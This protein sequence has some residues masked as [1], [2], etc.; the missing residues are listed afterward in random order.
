M[1]RVVTAVLAMG[2]AAGVGLGTRS[3]SAAP[4]AAGRAKF[5]DE[6]VERAI[7]KGI[8]YLLSRQKPDGSWQHF[9]G[10]VQHQESGPTALCVYALLESGVSVQNAKIVKA[11]NWLV[12]HP[13]GMTYSV[14]CRAN[15]WLSANMQS[16]G[17]YA[18]YLSNDARILWNAATNG[19]YNYSA[20]PGSASKRYDNSN[21]QFGLLGVWAKEQWDGEVPT[22]YWQVV[23]RHWEQTQLGDGGWTYGGKHAKKGAAKGTMTAGGV[24]SLFVC[25]DNLFAAKFVNCGRKMDY[26]PI[27]RGLAWFDKNF[28]RT[29]RDVTG[30][31][32][33]YYYLYGIERVGLAA[34]Y[35]YFGTQDWY[36]I[37]AM[38]LIANQR[39]NGSWLNTISGQVNQE[40]KPKPKPPAK[41]AKGKDAKGK[42]GAKKKQA[43]VDPGTGPWEVFAAKKPA[44]KKPAAKAKRPESRP[45]DIINTCFSLLFLIRGRQ[46]VLFNKLEFDSDW[47]NRPRDLASLTRWITKTFERT[48]NWQIVNLKVPVRELHDAPLLYISASKDPKFTKQQLAKLRRYVQEGGCLFS[49]TECGGKA[50]DDGIRKVYAKLFPE[51]ELVPVGKDHPIYKAHFTLAGMPKISILS[52]GVRPLAVHTETDLSKAWQLRNTATQKYTFEAAANIYMYVTDYGSLRHRGTSHWPAKKPGS[53]KQ[54]IEIVRLKNSGNCN[55]EPL[56]FERFALLMHNEAGITVKATSP[57][58]IASLGKGDGKIAVM[59]GTGE[60]T[61]SSKEEQAIKSFVEGGG[62]LV[63][64]AAG[65]PKFKED[66][67]TQV[68]RMVGFSAAAERAIED[69]FGAGS[70][71]QMSMTSPVLGASGKSLA[72]VKYR[73]RTR[74][75]LGGNNGA[76][77]KTVLIGSRPGVIYSRE[78]ITAG[79]VGFESSTVDGYAP[80]SAFAVMRNIVLH[81]G[82]RKAAGGGAK[83]ARPTRTER[84]DR[85]KAD[86]AE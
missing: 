48:V 34:G 70:L 69:I 42:N 54:T 8:K 46:P 31:K 14:A 39:G 28:A 78:D 57:R 23:M 60:F 86:K 2:L 80:D 71:R 74:K 43:S 85:R 67:N 24:A 44:A 82:G 77:L 25:F 75:R 9:T 33:G 47:N 68:G 19:A 12:K 10:H 26:K 66:A 15:A 73:R 49:V 1:H 61:L 22:Q 41:D 64:D 79:L 76:N 18:Q 52:N 65:G 55:P 37:G 21:S 4:A 84:R 81:A 45:M 20:A 5:S 83:P 27:E 16:R 59:T 17:K 3:A 72:D 11:L 36:K 32:Q 53:P 7:A 62:T 40:P 56:A 38:K 6:A 35:K 58:A 50:F 29:V 13:S 51:Y 30:Q 63:V